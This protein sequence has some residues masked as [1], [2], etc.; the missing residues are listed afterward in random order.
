MKKIAP[1]ARQF[2]AAGIGPIS[3]R[4]SRRRRLLIVA[5][6]AIALAVG[7]PALIIYL[8]GPG[9][10]DGILRVTTPP[11]PITYWPDASNTGVPPGTAL[12]PSGSLTLRT[13]GQVVSNL[14][15][16]GCVTVDASNVRIIRTRIRCNNTSF[17]I[18]TLNTARNLVVEDV[19]IDG[20]GRVAASVCCANYT[21][22]RVNI[23]NSV[24]GPRISG[25]TAIL[26]SYIHN[27][28]RLPASHNDAL[29]TTGGSGIVIQR[30]TLLPYNVATSDPANACLMVGSETAPSVQ[31]MLMVDNYCN[32]GNWSI[33]IRTDLVAVQIVFRGNKF[34]RNYR[35]GVVARPRHPG[36]TWESSNVFFDNGALVVR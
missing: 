36:V 15:I 7:A 33:G 19:E 27:L 10:D 31:N 35:Y 34:G 25:N 6:A 3:E 11:T 1:G 24:D 16:T 20:Q 4:P 2:P 23:H 9:H 5:A 26:D 17:A 13:S 8:P 22:R 12:R 21:L 30:N 18:R 14:D 28:A 29:Q 32:G